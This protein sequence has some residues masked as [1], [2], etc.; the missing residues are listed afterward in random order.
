MSKELHRSHNG[1][2]LFCVWFYDESKYDRGRSNSHFEIED[3][4]GKVIKKGDYTEVLNAYEQMTGDKVFKDDDAKKKQ[5]QKPQRTHNYL[6]KS[7]W[8]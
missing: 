3:Q 7:D 4:N 5:K 6:G 2:K 1:I 8:W